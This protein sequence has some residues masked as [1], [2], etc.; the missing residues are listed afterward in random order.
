MFSPAS[1]PGRT[2]PLCCKENWDSPESR[3]YCN[4]ASGVVVDHAN[5]ML[6]FVMYRQRYPSSHVML[7]QTSSKCLCHTGK[8]HLF[9]AGRYSRPL[10]FCPAFSMALRKSTVPYSANSYMMLYYV[11]SKTAI[12]CTLIPVA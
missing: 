3:T 10:I 11:S 5:E 8:V 9:L 4:P 7:Q 12:W 1:R 6:L 2:P